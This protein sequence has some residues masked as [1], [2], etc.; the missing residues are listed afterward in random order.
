MDNKEESSCSELLAVVDEYKSLQEM[1]LLET[2]INPE[3]GVTVVDFKR[4]DAEPLYRDM[5]NKHKLY[6][7]H[8]QRKNFTQLITLSL[9]KIENHFRRKESS[10]HN[11]F[12][13]GKDDS[14][15]V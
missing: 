12:R 2:R 7:G 1:V 4:G 15:S 11:V 14:K 8:L 5:D 9:P 6:C 3:Q 10:E 13:I